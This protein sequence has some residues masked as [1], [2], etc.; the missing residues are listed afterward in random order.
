MADDEN[1]IVTD[2]EPVEVDIK[3]F[4]PMFNDTAVSFFPEIENSPENIENVHQSEGGRKI[5]QS[6]RKD[7]LSASV[8]LKVADFSW[9]TF[10][11]DLYVNEDSVTFKQFSPLLSA[12]ETR[13]VRIVNFKYKKVKKS[14]DLAVNG[15]WEM[16]FGIEE[17]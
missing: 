14:E 8:K 10:F 7:V 17:F 6:V 11:Y 3:Q 16:S 5:V 15:T 2:D 13:T 12:Y 4:P 1:I 9:V